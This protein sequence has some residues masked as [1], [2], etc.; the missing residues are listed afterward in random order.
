MDATTSSLIGAGIGALAG[1]AGGWLNGWRQS[2]IEHEKWRRSRYDTVERD[3]RLALADL[4]KKLA[5]GIHAIAWITWKAKHETDK[6]S[7]SGLSAYDTTM[8]TLFPDI[9]GSRVSLAA[10]NRVSHD[11]VSPLIE[12]LYAFDVRIAKAAALYRNSA[13]EGCRALAEC[14]DDCLQFDKVFLDEVTK[15]GIPKMLAQG[16]GRT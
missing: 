3:A 7:E 8:K 14:H 2:K 10:L 15:I 11:L 16:D 4:T 5:M 6:L 12:Q 1:L 13:L 9:V